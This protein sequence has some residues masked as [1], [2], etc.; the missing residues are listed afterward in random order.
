[1]QMQFRLTKL[2]QIH[3]LDTAPRIFHNSPSILS[4]NTKIEFIRAPVE[5][6]VQ[7]SNEE[8]ALK[9]A[10]ML[11]NST[12]CR[13]R[14]WLVRDKFGGAGVLPALIDNFPN[15]VLSFIWHFQHLIGTWE[16]L[17]KDIFSK[18]LIFWILKSWF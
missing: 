17:E 14:P 18:Q 1:M 12:Y 3:L 16:L 7:N 4:K 5:R 8:A 15:E 2:H 11:W 6:N 9:K 13:F 10:H